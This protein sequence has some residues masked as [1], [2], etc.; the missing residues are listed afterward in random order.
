MRRTHHAVAG[1]V[2]FGSPSFREP[3]PADVLRTYCSAAA[4]A[5]GVGAA[6]API[7]R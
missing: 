5:A 7:R 1:L 4:H 6:T 2:P 3:V